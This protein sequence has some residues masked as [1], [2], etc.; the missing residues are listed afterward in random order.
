MGTI[1]GSW[2]ERQETQLLQEGWQKPRHHRGSVEPSCGPGHM[3]R[4][5]TQS[6]ATDLDS[7]MNLAKDDRMDWE[8][9]ENHL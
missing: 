5:G 9:G 6:V 1:S 8:K 7:E 3:W 4:A 2:H